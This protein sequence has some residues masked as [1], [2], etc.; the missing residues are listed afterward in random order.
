MSLIAH[1]KLNG[2]ANDVTGNGNH[3]TPTDVSWVVGKIGQA[4]SFNGWNSVIALPIT[5]GVTSITF[6]GWFYCIGSYDMLRIILDIQT[7]RT[8]FFWLNG[9]SQVKLGV[10]DG[11]AYRYFGATPNA[12]EW[13]HVAFVCD[14]DAGK[15]NCYVDGVQSGSEVAYIPRAI[16]GKVRLSG[17]YGYS[18]SYEF[19]GYMDDVRIYNE[20]LPEWKIQAIYDFGRGSEEC[21]PGQRLIRP[22]ARKLVQ[23]LIGA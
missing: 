6:M 7:G 17:H 12:N 10:Y 1:Y 2:D 21:E 13:H 16:G 8:F 19:H 9:A 3:G 4:A 22:I 18:T 11:T 23:P 20:V 15:A 14:A 5:T